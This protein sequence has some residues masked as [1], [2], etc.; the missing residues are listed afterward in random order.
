MHK[1]R[2]DEA[3]VGAD[4]VLVYLLRGARSAAVRQQFLRMPAEQYTLQR[5][6]KLLVR[7][8]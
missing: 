3:L 2:A 7:L 8:R 5:E 4:P 6:V 1:S